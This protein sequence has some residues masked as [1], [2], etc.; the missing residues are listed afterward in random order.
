MKELG[1]LALVG[2]LTM[3]ENPREGFWGIEMGND[4]VGGVGWGF[5]GRFMGHRVKWA[6]CWYASMESVYVLNRIIFV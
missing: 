6:G 2:S 1:G 5:F 3:P 4:G